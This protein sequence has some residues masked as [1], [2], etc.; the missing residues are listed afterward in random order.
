MFG[1]VFQNFGGMIPIFQ[2]LRFSSQTVIKEQQLGEAFDEVDWGFRL[3]VEIESDQNFALKSGQV[4]NTEALR[5]SLFG[6]DQMHHVTEVGS[7]GFVHFNGQKKA[8]DSQ[9]DN[10][11]CKQPVLGQFSQ[12]PIRNTHR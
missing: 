5:T 8:D 6:W 10:R 4:G 3:Q 2:I 11:R 7:D 1:A 9:I 12:V